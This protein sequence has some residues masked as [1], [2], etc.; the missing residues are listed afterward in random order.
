VSPL[1][2]EAFSYVAGSY[3]VSTERLRNLLG[4]DFEKVIRY[5]AEAALRDSFAEA[6]IRQ[7]TPAG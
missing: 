7:A 1:P 3:T 6:P 2:P 4:G 5:S